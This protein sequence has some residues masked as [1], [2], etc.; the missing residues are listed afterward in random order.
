M[1]GYESMFASLWEWPTREG[2][3]EG[4]ED[5]E[6]QSVCMTRGGAVASR[7]AMGGWALGRH[8]LFG[9]DREGRSHTDH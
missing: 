4:D 3:Q 9:K 7:A 8:F 5:L 1:S 2:A 6:E